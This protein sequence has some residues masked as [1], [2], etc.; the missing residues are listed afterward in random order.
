MKKM[1]RLLRKGGWVAVF[2]VA[3]LI[4]GCGIKKEVEGEKR[5]VFYT[6]VEELSIPE[7][8]KEVVE[9]KKEQPFQISFATGEELYLAVGY[10]EQP[11]G[12]YRIV[13]EG[14]FETDE[15]LYLETNLFGPE[16]EDEVSGKPDCPY[17]VVKTTYSDKS[18]YYQ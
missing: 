1:E 18:I 8:L 5:E 4:S 14:F 9:R 13:V 7:E 15:G 6:V 2:F 10:G 17:I 3:A 11:T 12:G 16:K